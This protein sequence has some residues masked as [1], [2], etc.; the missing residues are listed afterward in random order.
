M[1][2]FWTLLLKQQKT[3]QA[4]L[5]KKHAK[6]KAVTA[7]EGHAD[8][9]DDEDQEKDEDVDVDDYNNEKR[10]SFSSVL[11]GLLRSLQTISLDLQANAAASA[12][13]FASGVRN[14]KEKAYKSKK[15][16]NNAVVPSG[17]VDFLLKK[18]LLCFYLFYGFLE[19]RPF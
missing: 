9:V 7:L 8:D 17:D 2:R 14:T 19:W 10:L 18:S 11:R 6:L 1:T 4:P 13:R 16:L 3:T 15:G 12:Q 5:R